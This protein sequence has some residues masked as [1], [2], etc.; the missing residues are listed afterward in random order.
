M[1]LGVEESYEN[2]HRLGIG[3]LAYFLAANCPP[4][5]KFEVFF[6]AMSCQIMSLVSINRLNQSI[7]YLAW[8]VRL[9]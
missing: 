1:L 9:A 5:L 7:L 8:S 2:R 3:S 6:R 4:I